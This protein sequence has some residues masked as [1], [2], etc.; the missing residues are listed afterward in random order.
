MREN[1]IKKNNV[2]IVDGTN[3]IFRNYFVHTYRKTKEGVH[4]GGIYGTIRSLKS[5]VDNFDPRQIFICFDKSNQ[6]FRNEMYEE[7]K[8][9]RKKTE[10][11]LKKQFPILKE[12]CNLANIPFIEKDR[13]EADDIIGSLSCN[14]SNYG[15][16]PYAVTGDKDILQLIDKSI[17]ILYLS[18]KGPIIYG[19]ENLI[20]EYRINPEQFIDYKALVGD[21]SD[22][23]PGVPGVGKK[24]AA[25]LLGLYDS[26]DGIYEN[27]ES[28]KG[29][30]KEKIIENK[31]QAYLSKKLSEIVCDMD[32]DYDDYFGRYIE[33]GFNMKDEKVIN[34]L[35]K[36]EIKS[37]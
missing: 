4:T 13:Y 20:D 21:P 32:L 36:L 12:Y 7:Y 5:Y 8:G 28:L 2:L 34:F 10:E 30:Q 31:E 15:L 22:N 29:K 37:Q 24:T 18:N 26:L 17:D 23:I 1:K 33:E 3:L 16:N 25:K 6:T 9:K 14:A 11:D 35:N 27:V 19:E